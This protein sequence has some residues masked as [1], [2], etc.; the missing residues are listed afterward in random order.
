MRLAFGT[1]ELPAKF[2]VVDVGTQQVVFE[3]RRR[4]QLTEA[5]GQFKHHAELDFSRS[6]KTGEYFLRL[7]IAKSP[8][9]RISADVYAEL[10]DQLLEFM[11]QQRCGYN[12]W[13]DEVCHSFDGRTADGPLPAGSYVDARGGWHDAGDQLKYLL[14]SSNA[15]AQMLL[16]YQLAATRNGPQKFGDR[17]NELGQ[18]R[19]EWHRR[20]AR[21]SAVGTRLD[22]A[23][24]PGAGSA[25]SPGGRR[26]RSSPAFGCRKMKRS[27]TAGGR[28]VIAPVYSADGKPQG[29]MQYKS[30]SNGVANLAGRYAAAMALGYQIWKDDPQLR[31]YA[32]RLL[33]GGQGSVCDGESQRRRAAG[34]FVQSA[35]SLRGNDVG[36]RHGMGRGRTVRATGDAEYRDDAMR[37]AELAGTEGWF[38]QEKIGHYQYYP[39]MNVGHFRLYDLVDD[40]TQEQTGRLLSRTDRAVREGS[41]GNPYRVGVPFIWCSNNLTVAL[42][43]QC[44]LYERMTGDT[45]YRAFAARPS[46]L[47]VGAQ[48]VGIFDVHGDSRRAAVIRRDVHLFGNRVAEAAGPRRAGRWPGCAQQSSAA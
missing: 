30:E 47:A 36:R 5:W 8:T 21:R 38:G 34:Q 46:R 28:A 40:T 41:A 23:A 2:Q 29:L 43:T 18:P 11:R 16:A 20:F 7:G 37:Y 39:F 26:P 24:A 48:S 31:P 1:S 27:I 14:T 13:V 15:T 33:A 44:A 32:E 9:F 25:L 35:V 17:V 19:A 45:R 6:T 22:A 3:G 10:P 12:P 4:G 42:A